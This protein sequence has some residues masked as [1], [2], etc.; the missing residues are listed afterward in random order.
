MRATLYP[1]LDDSVRFR[2]RLDRFIK[3]DGLKWK[4]A[5]RAIRKLSPKLILLIMRAPNDFSTTLK[6]ARVAKEVDPN[7]KIGVGG[8]RRE[9]YYRHLSLRYLKSKA[10]DFVIVG[11]PEHTLVEVS[12]KLLRGEEIRKI[13]GLALKNRTGKIVFTRRREFETDLDRFP[14]PNRDLVIDKKYY[15]PSGFGLVEGARGCAYACKFCLEGGIPLRFRSPKNVVREMAQVYVRYGTRQ[16]HFIMSSFLHSK[17]WAREV[18]RLIKKF[19]LDIIFGCYVNENQVER[20]IIQV[21]KSTGCYTLGIG[22][23][24]GD[25]DI[26][27]Q[28]GKVSNLGLRRVREVAKMIKSAGIFLRAGIIIGN[29]GENLKQMAA[30]LA[31]LRDTRP[32]FFRVQFFVPMVGTELYEELRSKNMLVDENIDEYTTA[33]IKVRPAISPTILKSVW[34]RY[35]K[36]SN[37]SDSVIW[38]KKFLN[39]KILKCKM[40]EYFRHVTSLF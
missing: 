22:F 23:E 20:K 2:E 7:V 1:K 3:S 19:G 6:M 17:K 18:C 15:P 29:P 38:R 25:C 11:E 10:I 4:Y 12:K 21:L 30:S 16:F 28:M 5:K 36:I 39:R 37:L 32:D 31:L 35:A 33:N 8:W 13:R 40:A 24:S 34:M 14:I 27:R 9:E 26:L